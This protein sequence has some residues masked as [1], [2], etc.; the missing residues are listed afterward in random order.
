MDSLESILR[1]DI[2]PER[3]KETCKTCFDKLCYFELGGSTKIGKLVG[4]EMN[5]QLSQLYYIIQTPNT[6]DKFYISTDRS[7]SK[8]V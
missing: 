5:F 8:L 3:V 4:L 7:I 2:I 6:K 1:N